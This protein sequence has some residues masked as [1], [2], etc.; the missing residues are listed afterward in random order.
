M[1]EIS[2]VCYLLPYNIGNS[3]SSLDS[4]LCCLCTHCTY[5]ELQGVLNELGRRKQGLTKFCYLL[6]STTLLHSSSHLAFPFSFGQSPFIDPFYLKYECKGSEDLIKYSL[7]YQAVLSLKVLSK[8]MEMDT[9]IRTRHF[10]R[11]STT[12]ILANVKFISP[13]QFLFESPLI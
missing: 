2:A 5:L 7:Q 11:L 8:Y 6:T 4:C 9:S 12:L 13:C 1:M 3:S 10:V